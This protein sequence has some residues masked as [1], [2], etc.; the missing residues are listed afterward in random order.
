MFYYKGEF[1]EADD[2]DLEQNYFQTQL[3]T[4]ASHCFSPGLTLFPQITIPTIFSISPKGKVK[5][6]PDGTEAPASFYLTLISKAPPPA[7]QVDNYIA[8][9]Q[10][11]A[12]D[13]IG[14]PITILDTVNILKDTF[15]NIEGETAYLTIQYAE[16]LS[17]TSSKII[18]EQ[19]LFQANATDN[20]DTQK[21]YLATVT[22]D[23]TDKSIL[24]LAIDPALRL[25]ARPYTGMGE[26]RAKEESVYK[27]Q[28]EKE[29]SA[30]KQRLSQLETSTTQTKK[31][32]KSTRRSKSN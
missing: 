21:L 20:S 7:S 17:S 3:R 16:H 14:N 30:L 32:P 4:F 15:Q 24:S 10:G 9:N 25:Y 18:V 6:E 2:F 5:T 11:L 1:L 13:V 8:V 26:I 19:P 23:P 28:F 27:E 12:F 22:L 31:T 29:I